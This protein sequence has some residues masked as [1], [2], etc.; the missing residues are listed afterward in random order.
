MAKPLTQIAIDNLRPRAERYEAPDGRITG[1]YLVV[2]PSGA[3]SWAARYR[4]LGRQRKYTIGPYP[5]LDLAAA[6]RKA[7]EALGEVAGGRDPAAQKKAI[8]EAAKAA[9]SGK[10]TVAGVAVSFI[11]RYA[12]R[13]VGPSWARQSERLIKREILPAI[14]DKR[15]CDVKRSDIHDL[16]DVIIDRGSPITANRALSVFRRLCNWAI[17][18]GIL[19]VSTCDKIKAPS[20]EISR[21]RFLSADE[22]QVAWRAFERVGWPWGDIGKLL[23]LTGQRRSE[24]AGMTWTEVDLAAKTWTIAKERSKNGL[25]H[26][27]PLSSAATRI[28]EDL[29]RI[30]GRDFIFSLVG[31]PVSGFSRAKQFTIDR[32]L[33]REFPHWTFHDLRRTAASG[34]AGI[35]IAPHVVEA[36]LNHRN[37]TI[38][39][40]AAV[41]N[42]YSYAAEKRTALDAW[43]R[44]LH[45]IVTG[46]KPANVVE[47]MKAKG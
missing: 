4:F 39:G 44:K 46:E 41:Y 8:R 31:K 35:G 19:A 47:L 11:E 21:D 14:G 10:D 23:L 12:K 9:Q 29:P 6:R 7:L 25:A 37:G 28:L 3:K 24:V 2:Q 42:R 18:R 5:T 26:E 38:K 15:L 20:A 22:I 13:H 33:D 32:A 1:L 30:E 16:L 34:M 17:E 43:A 40:V 45:E 27:V 36:I